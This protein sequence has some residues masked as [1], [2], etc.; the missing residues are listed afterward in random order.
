MTA[1]A[2]EIGD[3]LGV[4]YLVTFTHVRRLRQAAVAAPRSKLPLLAFTPERGRR[5]PSWR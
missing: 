4:K 3:L 5:A 1:A 2:A